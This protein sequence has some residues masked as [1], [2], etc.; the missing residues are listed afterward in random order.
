MRGALDDFAVKIRRY[1]RTR[2]EVRSREDRTC[3]EGTEEEELVRSLLMHATRLS[4][5]REEERSIIMARDRPTPVPMEVRAVCKG[6]GKVKEKGMD[7]GKLKDKDKEAAVNL[8]A[9]VVCNN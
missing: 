4:C 1:E 3:P 6:K 5:V 7:K 8:D 2:G 9:E